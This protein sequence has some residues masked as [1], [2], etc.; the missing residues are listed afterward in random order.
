MP[1]PTLQ[2]AQLVLRPFT[3]EDAPA[4]QRLAGAHEVA[5][6]TLTIPHPY[7]DGMAE[8]WI[9]MEFEGVLRQLVLARGEFEDVAV[10]AILSSDHP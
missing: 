3:L 8:E 2:T 1:I 5:S 10:Y 7:E 6:T 4:V 9:G